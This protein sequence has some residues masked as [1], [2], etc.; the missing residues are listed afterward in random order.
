MLFF[1]SVEQFVNS[2]AR[3]SST[4]H[5]SIMSNERESRSWRI[6]LFNLLQLRSIVSSQKAGRPGRQRQSCCWCWNN[7]LKWKIIKY[8]GGEENI[9]QLP[10]VLLSFP[11]CFVLCCV[12]LPCFIVFFR[13]V[14]LSCP[15]GAWKMGKNVKIVKI[16][17]FIVGSLFI[18]YHFDL[19]TF[20]PAFLPSFQI[21]SINWL[22][23]SSPIQLQFF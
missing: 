6:K 13:V 4:E 5:C 16:I 22:F 11:S 23:L 3:S 20:S 18:P 14:I 15:H 10:E 21:N 8:G 7:K 17:S 1:S 19:L 2:S 12:L 9:L